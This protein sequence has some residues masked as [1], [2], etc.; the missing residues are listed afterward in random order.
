M[1]KKYV[2]IGAG[3][4]GVTAAETIRAKD[5]DGAITIINGEPFP[6]YFRAAM[7]FYIKGAI[8]EDELYG[9]P[10]VWAQKN[11]IRT[12]NDRVKQV[13]VDN[14]EV[15]TQNGLTE[16]YDKLLVATGAWPF[17]APW[18]G[19]DLDGVVTYRSLTCARHMID[20]IKKHA[21]KKAVVVG[22]GILGVELVEDLHNLGLETTL[23]A[24]ESRVLELLLDPEGSGIILD[25]MKSDGVRVL[26]KTELKEIIGKDGRVEGIVTSGG[27]TIEAGLVGVAIGVRPHIDFLEGS[28]LVIDR[29][30]IVDQRLNTSDPD[31]YS[32]GDVAVRKVNGSYIPCRTWLTAARQGRVAGA[33]MVEGGEPFEEKVFFN[34]SHA[35]KSIYSAVGK[36]DEPEGG[37]IRHIRLEAGKGRYS[38]L[39]MD[40]D[41]I[42]GGVF[43]GYVTPV[44][45]VCR[46]IESGAKVDPERLAGLKGSQLTEILT[47]GPPLLF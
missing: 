36:Y 23:L 15:C 28:G 41:R 30:V 2:I 20:Y 38:K 26:F 40:G 4:A 35:Y 8:T 5:P 29:G 31:V 47:S 11:N 18:P 44:W 6:F 24:R 42:I 45:D 43:I 32:A 10:A 19:A 21:V 37:D 13:R 25:Q 1:K 34:A 17:V 3:V 14:K 33:N 39:V 7:S 22:G 9:K 16:P 12:L 27:E 46:A